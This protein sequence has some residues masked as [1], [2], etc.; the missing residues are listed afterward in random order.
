MRLDCVW[1]VSTFDKSFEKVH[2]VPDTF[3]ARNQLLVE[4]IKDIPFLR[5]VE[6]PQKYKPGLPQLSVY[7]PDIDFIFLG[8]E[9]L[10]DEYFLGGAEGAIRRKVVNMFTSVSPFVGIKRR[11]TVKDGKVKMQSLLNSEPFDYFADSMGKPIVVSRDYFSTSSTTVRNGLSADNPDARAELRRAL[12]RNAAAKLLDDPNFATYLG[13]LRQQGGNTTHKIMIGMKGLV[14]PDDP[15]VISPS[16]TN[17]N[18]QNGPAEG[19][20]I[21]VTN[22]SPLRIQT[23]FEATM[24]YLTSEV[25]VH[26]IVLQPSVPL[27]PELVETIQL[28][29]KRYPFLTLDAEF[30]RS[31]PY[32]LRIHEQ[33]VGEPA[34]PKLPSNVDMTPDAQLFVFPAWKHGDPDAQGYTTYEKPNLGNLPPGTHVFHDTLPSEPWKGNTLYQGMID[35][36]EL[37]AEVFATCVEIGFNLCSKK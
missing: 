24:V 29:L 25:P 11:T 19:R 33:N 13:L 9:D 32:V 30:D 20:G 7:R 10:V 17:T 5:M 18:C 28:V 21:F 15:L 12:G 26:C 16:Q 34:L 4:I 6:L 35:Q 23:L 27:Y 37:P 31:P 36:A 14:R 3:D 22:L 2:V 8:G 1:I